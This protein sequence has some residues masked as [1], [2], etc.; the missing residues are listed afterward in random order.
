M[1][2]N[3]WTTLEEYHFLED[4]IPKL[5]ISRQSGAVAPFYGETTVTFLATFPTRVEECTRKD[6]EKVCFQR[7]RLFFLTYV[8]QRIRHWFGNHTR[9]IGKVTD[10]RL[11]LD[12]SGR[13]KRQ[14]MPLQKSQAYSALYYKEGSALSLE[15]KDAYRRYA[16]GDETTVSR[17]KH[18]FKQVM[19][20]SNPSASGEELLSTIGNASPSTE[21]IL[22]STEEP[23]VAESES[24][25]CKVT[26]F[27]HFQQTLIREKL[28][29]ISPDEEAAVAQYIDVHYGAA[30]AAWQWPWMATPKTSTLPE[31]LSSSCNSGLSVEDL[32]IQ[33]YQRL[34]DCVH[35]LVHVLTFMQE[36]QPSRSL[37]AEH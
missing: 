29:V 22:P 18:L 2:S 7:L 36:C 31:E 25:A 20:P 15:I 10:S 16:S 6:W 35:L 1:R 5:I 12:L 13:C 9:H 26:A 37:V 4:L 34:A 11:A 27:V 14:P 21:D 23:A 33:Y 30:L 32:E 24:P 3:A 28:K 19:D 17:Y 8:A